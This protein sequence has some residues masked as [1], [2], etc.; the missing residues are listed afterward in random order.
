M[1]TGQRL[2][3]EAVISPGRRDWMLAAQ[4]SDRPDLKKERND[5]VRDWFL[6]AAL[7]EPLFLR[8]PCKKTLQELLK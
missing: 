8:P 7:D 6:R 2:R 4:Q 3:V 5:Q 1:L